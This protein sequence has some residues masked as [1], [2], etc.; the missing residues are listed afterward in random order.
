MSVTQTIAE[1]SA[2]ADNRGIGLIE[3]LLALG[4]SIIIVTSMVSL[5]IFTLRASLENK[6]LLS[7]T[8]IANQEIEL[9]RAYRDSRA[10]DT[11][12]AAVSP[13]GLNCFNSDC[14]MNN[15]GTLSVAGGALVI[16]QGSNEEITKSFRLT[17]VNNDMSLIRVAVTVS[18]TLGSSTKYTHS[19]TELSDWR[20][21]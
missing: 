10:W 11:F 16:N 15:S 12:T 5:A 18:W 4:L 13:P 19:Y 7:G 9:I 21:L 20:S 3:T 2:G 14:H 17:D 8:Q 1:K 6:L